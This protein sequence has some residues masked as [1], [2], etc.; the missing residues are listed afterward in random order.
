MDAQLILSATIIATSAA[1][2]I[3]ALRHE[4]DVSWR[5]AS[6]SA[7]AIIAL[8]ATFAFAGLHILAAAAL[9]CIIPACVIICEIDRRHFII[10]DV[11]VA[12]LAIV[13]IAAP[14][15]SRGEQALGALIAGGLFFAVRTGFRQLRGAHGLGL[16]DL[17]LAAVMGALLG[18]SLALAAIAVAAGATAAAL[19]L[20]SARTVN[21]APNAAPFGVGLSAALAIAVMFEAWR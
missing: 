14:F 17:K 2:C 5:T 4:L 10:P 16:G 11:L 18:P 13:A 8:T 19:A 9:G 3:Y 6:L 21:S 7:I 1:A 20:R 12:T 15:T